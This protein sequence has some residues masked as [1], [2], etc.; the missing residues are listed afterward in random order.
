[1]LYEAPS[2]ILGRM[3][4]H[5]MIAKIPATK[6]DGNIAF[7]AKLCLS[8]GNILTDIDNM[9]IFF[10]HFDFSEDNMPLIQS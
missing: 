5:R 3:E 1:M 4:Q 9:L 6:R 8:P 10:L 7:A 2:T